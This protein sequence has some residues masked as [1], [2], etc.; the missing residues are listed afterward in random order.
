MDKEYKEKVK[1]YYENK[2]KDY[3][4][5]KKETDK[6]YKEKNKEKIKEKNKEYR[7]KNKDKRQEIIMCECGCETTKH[8]LKRHE[9][10][11]KHKDLYF[12]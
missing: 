5:R 12:K 11:K 9:E 2:N 10:T 4:E 7:E 6:I 3:K 1:E 8:H